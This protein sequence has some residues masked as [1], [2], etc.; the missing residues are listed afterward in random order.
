VRVTHN[1]IHDRVFSGAIA[2]KG[3]LVNVHAVRLG[4]AT[5]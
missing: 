5:S 3:E 1:T 2:T 4:A